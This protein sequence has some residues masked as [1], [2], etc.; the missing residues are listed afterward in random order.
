MTDWTKVAKPGDVVRFWSWE[1][2]RFD[3]NNGRGRLV[4]GDLRRTP[5]GWMEGK[6]F[7]RRPWGECS[8]LLALRSAET[9]VAVQLLRA[10]RELVRLRADADCIREAQRTEL[11]RLKQQEQRR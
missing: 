5:K 11:R 1:G 3:E 8:I 6:V 2:D 4:W 7:H 9:V 10:E